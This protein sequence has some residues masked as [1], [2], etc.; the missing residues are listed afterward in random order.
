MSVVVP[1]FDRLP[2]L[3]DQWNLD[4]VAVAVADAAGTLLELAMVFLIVERAP[5]AGHHHYFLA[6]VVEVAAAATA[7]SSW[8]V[9]EFLKLSSSLDHSSMSQ[10]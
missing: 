7:G 2:W 9:M 8:L 6:V 3:L 10:N 1:Y 4:L 5:S